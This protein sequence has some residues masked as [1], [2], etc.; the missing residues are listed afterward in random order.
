MKTG[1]KIFEDAHDHGD[2]YFAMIKTEKACIA[3]GYRLFIVIE[4]EML[5]S[6][7]KIAKRLI[8]FVNGT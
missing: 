6:P 2:A 3:Q 7:E 1:V 8:D 5:A 4:E